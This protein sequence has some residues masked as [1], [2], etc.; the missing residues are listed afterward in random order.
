MADVITNGIAGEAALV[1][2]FARF[3]A[4]DVDRSALVRGV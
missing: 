1:G 4:G 2:V 3:V